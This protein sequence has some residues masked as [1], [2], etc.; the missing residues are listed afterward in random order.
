MFIPFFGCLHLT[1]LLGSKYKE[2]TPNLIPSEDL[3]ILDASV[4]HAMSRHDR[5][6]SIDTLS[7]PQ[8]HFGMRVRHDRHPHTFKT[9]WF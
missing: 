3:Q 5:V 4:L 2:R 1:S 7:R 9:V 8:L 6:S